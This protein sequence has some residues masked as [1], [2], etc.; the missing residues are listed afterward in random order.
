MLDSIQP[1]LDEGETIYAGKMN[2]IISFTGKNR[3][4]VLGLQVYGVNQNK[5]AISWTNPISLTKETREFPID[6]AMHLNKIPID[7]LPLLLASDSTFSF[8]VLLKRGYVF[9]L[10]SLEEGQ[11]DFSIVLFDP[12]GNRSIP[13]V[14]STYIFGQAYENSLI[15]RNFKSVT[16]VQ[17]SA[18]EN[19]LH[20]RW[21]ISREPT[22]IGCNLEYDKADGTTGSLFVAVSDTATDLAGYKPKGEWRYSTSYQPSTLSLDAFYAAE[23]RHTLP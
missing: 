13:T 12:Q 21:V 11:H 2:Y 6:P 19:T 5:C 14:A 16:T 17:S 8:D 3:A 18:E 23:E 1:Y 20:I 15:N 22:L 10:D 9:E 7:S 4:R